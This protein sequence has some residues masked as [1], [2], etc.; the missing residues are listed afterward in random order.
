M[1]TR[2]GECCAANRV[3]NHRANALRLHNILHF[4]KIPVQLLG[5]C[6]VQE[7]G[8]IVHYRRNWISTAELID[9]YLHKGL[10][11]TFDFVQLW[12]SGSY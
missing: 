5:A 3:G 6:K 1:C 9:L 10:E 11:L 4:L 7:S 8:L 2:C 12:D